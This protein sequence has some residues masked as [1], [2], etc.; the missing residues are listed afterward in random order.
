[1]KFFEDIWGFLWLVF[2]LG[3]FLGA[4]VLGAAT[5]FAVDPH[6]ACVEHR[7]FLC[8]YARTRGQVVNCD[9]IDRS[10]AP[11]WRNCERHFDQNE[12]DCL[13]RIPTECEHL[14]SEK[15]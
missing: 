13:D 11:A 15:P 14:L 10:H 9:P 2:L 12:R 4:L 6:T 3:L 5:A 7:I 8:E 1:M